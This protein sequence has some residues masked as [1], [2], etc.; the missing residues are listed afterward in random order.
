M[1][2]IRR[3][4]LFKIVAGAALLATGGSFL[5]SENGFLWNL[6]HQLR[7]RVA[8]NATPA[9]NQDI[10]S[11]MQGEETVLY[12]RSQQTD[13]LKLNPMA[14]RIWEMCDGSH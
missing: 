7:Y 13:I 12:S 14:G 3:R 11:K 10:V 8:I 9:R 2:D 5:A 6:W 1:M 4:S